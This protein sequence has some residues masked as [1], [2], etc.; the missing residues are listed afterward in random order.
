MIPTLLSMI[1]PNLNRFHPKRRLGQHFL[2]SPDMLRRITEAA[3]LSHDDT[4]LEIG[5]GTGTLTRELLRKAGA[6]IAVE[7]DTRLSGELRKLAIENPNLQVVFGDI[8]KLFP[9]GLDLPERY[10]V[11]ANIPYYLTSRL[12]RKFLESERPPKAMFL[13]VQ[14]EVADRITAEPPDMNLLGLSVQAY[15][16]PEILFR[17]PPRAFSPPP[18]VDSAFIRIG[19]ISR[20]FFKTYGLNPE[21]F[22]RIAQAA[23]Q[24][25]RKTLENSLSHNLE[26]PKAE[27]VRAL[28]GLNLAGQRPEGLRADNWAELARILTPLLTRNPETGN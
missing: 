4:V 12:I 23:F 15:G 28:K 25:K 6:V 21:L 14:A 5:P 9:E 3:R 1:P 13:M 17:V 27:V 24:G 18:K 8:L 10:L 26:L 7:K 20:S 19:A 2:V 16:T 22:F 11:V